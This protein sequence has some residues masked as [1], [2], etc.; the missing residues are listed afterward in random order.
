MNRQNNDLPTSFLSPAKED[1]RPT[2]LRFVSARPVAMVCSFGSTRERPSRETTW[3]SQSTAGSSNFRTTSASNRRS[4]SLDLRCAWTTASGT[5]WWRT[6]GSGWASSGWTTSDPSRASRR[7]APRHST[8]TANCGSVAHP[9]SRTGCRGHTT[10]ASAGAST[11]CRW[12][13]A[14]WTWW[15]T[16]TRS[17]SGSATRC[18][19]VRRPASP[20]P[21]LR[22]TPGALHATPNSCASLLCWIM[23]LRKEN[24][25]ISR[26]EKRKH[27]WVQRLC[28][29][30]M[31]KKNKTKH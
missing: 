16:A 23:C 8:P 17:W 3:P 20:P 25:W 11:P 9:E 1:K 14:T 19:E 26:E 30:A 27:D 18:G 24:E 31:L 13:T 4:T 7:R 2:S 5:P 6:G 15:P 28:R 29:V 12:R 21:S 10:R 22:W